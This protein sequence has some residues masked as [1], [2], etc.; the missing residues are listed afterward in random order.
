MSAATSEI[1][2]ALRHLVELRGREH[3]AARP[4]EAG[5]AGVEFARRIQ[6]HDAADAVD[7]LQPAADMQRRGRDHVALGDDGE[8]GGAAADVEVEDALALLVR[9]LRRARAVGGE[10]RFHVVPGSGGDEIAALLGQERSDG[11]RILAPQRLAGEDDHAGVDVPGLQAG[12]RIGLVD[13]ARQRGVVDALVAGIGRE[14]H[15]RLE[16]GLPRHD[17]IAAGEVLAVAAQVDAGEDDL[18]A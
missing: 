8:L 16:Q 17:V 12:R 5:L 3:V 13:D 15:R 11:L 1:R 9:H 6:P 10:H 7:H 4:V 2:H 18:R 14:R